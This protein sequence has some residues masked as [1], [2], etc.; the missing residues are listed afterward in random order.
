MATQAGSARLATGRRRGWGRALLLSAA[1][2]LVLLGGLALRRAGAEWRAEAPVVDV[3]LVRL[4][5]PAAIEARAASSPAA[6]RP[7]RDATDQAAA[8]PQATR[9]GA[10]PE[11][12]ASPGIAIDPRWLVDRNGPAPPPRRE[13]DVDAFQ[14]CDPLKDPKRE[15]KACRKVDEIAESVTRSYDPQ[16]GQSALAREARHNEAGRRYREAPGMSGY[17]GIRCHVF[18]RC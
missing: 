5:P 15:S 10:S 7:P 11:T 8:P 13:L 2:H 17:S 9:D 1:L 4:P 18:H 14:P 3:R 12:P 6:G 16:R